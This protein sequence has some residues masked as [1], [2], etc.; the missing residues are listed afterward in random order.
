MLPC[1]ICNE[2]LFSVNDYLSHLRIKHA[3]IYNLSEFKC[4]FSN[5]S[6]IFSDVENFRRH[7]K[8]HT[9]GKI[10]TNNEIN[11]V[12]TSNAQSENALVEHDSNIET[13]ELSNTFLNSLS[14][15]LQNVGQTNFKNEFLKLTLSLLSDES[16]PRNKALL[17]IKK[18]YS[19]FKLILLPMKESLTK[20]VNDSLTPNK[21]LDELFLIFDRI[22]AADPTQSE[23]IIFKEL[24]N[25]G[26]FILPKK[27]ILSSYASISHKNNEEVIKN[28]EITSESI[29]L[30]NVFEKLYNV[31]GFLQATLKYINDFSCENNVVR[32]IMQ[33][34]HW[35]DLM[36]T[37]PSSSNVL[38]L[39]ICIFG[40]DFEPLNALGAHSGAYKVGAM[41]I[42]I[43]CLPPHML[44]KLKY[45]YF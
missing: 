7:L 5:C 37:L 32:N 33:G 39:P 31:P 43:P 12:M 38:Y 40:D 30:R 4:T 11:V 8:K 10:N 15:S 26:F 13:E 28:T 17:I 6:R 1:F 22:Y 3:Q 16:L 45:I 20:C 2:V 18:V 21:S 24:E 25:Q 9:S 29:P 41:Y 14:S 19:S 23:Y 34:S 36:S 27:N 35:K 44:S 42:K